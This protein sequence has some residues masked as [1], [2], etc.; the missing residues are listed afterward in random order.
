MMKSYPMNRSWNVLCW[1]VRGINRAEKWPLISNKIV[2]SNCEI[3]CFQE[4]KKESFDLAFIK[5]FA[6][7]RFDSFIFSPSVGASGGLLV[8][9]NGSIFHGTPIEV[10]SFAIIVCF[11]SRMDMSAWYLSTV[12]GPCLEPTRT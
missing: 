3:F 10:K 11:F 12:Y 1:N 6:P 2:E 5:N 9:W 7:K 4:T 8:V